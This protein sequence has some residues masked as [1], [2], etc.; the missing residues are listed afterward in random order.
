MALPDSQCDEEKKPKGTEPCSI[1][2][3][4]TTEDVENLDDELDEDTDESD[5]L[6]NDSSDGKENDDDNRIKKISITPFSG[7]IDDIDLDDDEE[8][9]E[10]IND[11]SNT[12]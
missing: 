10:R 11:L 9:L 1:P 3:C 7:H 2:L 6:L 4:N 8:S 12:I 5:D